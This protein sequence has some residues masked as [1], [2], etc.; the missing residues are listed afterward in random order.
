MKVQKIW[1]AV[2]SNR[3]DGTARSTLHTWTTKNSVLVGLETSDGVVGVGEAWC[4]G[5]SPKVTEAMIR[6]EFAPLVRGED[7]RF[8]EHI[9][10]KLLRTMI[11]SSRGGT[12]TAAMAAIDIALWDL[13]GKLVGRPIYQL[14]GAHSNKAPVYASGGMYGPTITPK[15]LAAEMLAALNAGACG[16]KIKGAGSSLE[17]EVARVSAL[18]EAI[19]DEGRLMV[20]AMFVLDVPRAI[21]LARALEPY[22]LHF[23][24][25]CTNAT[26]LRGWRAIREATIIPLAGPELQWSLDLMRDYLSAD[27]IH[28]LQF[29]VIL[30]GGISHGRRLA[31]LAEAFHKPVTLH[32]SASAVGLA[33]GAH[34]AAS[35]PNCDSLEYHVLHQSL[36]DRLWASGW[37]LEGGALSIPDAPGLGL[38]LDLA[39]FDVKEVTN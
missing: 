32:C 21:A 4:D 16:I 31:A 38:D 28:F 22:N 29:D 39:K 27:A 3:Y 33:A 30:A 7:P 26:D 2:V 9:R 36:F 11:L 13:A 35:I 34:L 25:A 5:A 8:I 18:R 20:D 1:T 24:E 15:S 23:L 17:E 6:E 12:A 37:K 10:S 14:L 19:G